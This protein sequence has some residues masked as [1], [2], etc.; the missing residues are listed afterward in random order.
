MTASETFE[1]NYNIIYP[2]GI[3]D[4]SGNFHLETSSPCLAVIIQAIAD[5][6]PTL[7]KAYFIGGQTQAL[8]PD[9]S[10]PY[11][12]FQFEQHEIPFL[13]ANYHQ[14]EFSVGF[15]D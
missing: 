6:E 2:D 3:P 10:R 1:V 15:R 4:K 12:H 8:Q 11:P 14:A 5:R 13:L 9:I 7:N